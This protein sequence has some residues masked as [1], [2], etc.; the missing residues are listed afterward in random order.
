MSSSHRGQGSLDA[1]VRSGVVATSEHPPQL[2]PD[3]CSCSPLK[4]PRVESESGSDGDDEPNADRMDF[5]HTEH[6]TETQAIDDDVDD[7]SHALPPPLNPEHAALWSDFEIITMMVM[8]QLYLRITADIEKSAADTTAAL[9]KNNDQLR[10]QITSL[11]AWI[12]QLQQQVLTYQGAVSATLPTVLPPK[13]DAK[14]KKKK[15]KNRFNCDGCDRIQWS[16]LCSR[17]SY[18]RKNSPNTDD[19][20]HHPRMDDPESRR[21]ER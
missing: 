12:T 10:N 6:I 11:G 7:A 18:R 9:R 8:Q 13:Q 1:F 21:P 3:A 2:L 16:F 4:R 19:D 14:K 20:H 17:C 15:K 5:H